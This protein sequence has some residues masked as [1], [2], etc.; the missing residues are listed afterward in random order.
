[1]AHYTHAATLTVVHGTQLELPINQTLLC[2][3]LEVLQRQIIVLEKQ[4]HC[5]LNSSSLWSSSE[6]LD[7]GVEGFTTGTPLPYR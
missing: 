4:R 6:R 7:C 5:D 2:G 1:M 3:L